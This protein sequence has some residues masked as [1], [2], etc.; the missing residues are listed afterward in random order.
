MKHIKTQMTDGTTVEGVITKL[1]KHFIEAPITHPFV[2][3][4]ANFLLLE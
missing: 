1:E 3:W 2:N 4:K